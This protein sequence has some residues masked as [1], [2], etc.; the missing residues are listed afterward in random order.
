VRT[1]QSLVTAIRA[2][3]GNRPRLIVVGGASTLEPGSPMS[4]HPAGLQHQQALDYLR[5]VKDVDWTYFSPASDIR[6]G[7]RTG[8]FRLSTTGLVKDASGK[9]SISTEDYAV[10]MIDEAEKPAHI[11]QPFTVG[12]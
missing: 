12:Y 7:T 4:Q 11:R 5:T 1:A 6:P 8:K 9:S 2:Q 10:A 3:K